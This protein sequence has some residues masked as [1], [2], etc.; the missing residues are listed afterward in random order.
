[1]YKF[2]ESFLGEY[3]EILG[4]IRLENSATYRLKI[5]LKIYILLNDYQFYFFFSFKLFPL[6]IPCSSVWTKFLLITRRAKFFFLTND[7]EYFYI[8]IAGFPDFASCVSVSRSS[9]KSARATVPRPNH[10][11]VTLIPW[12]SHRFPAPFE[13]LS[14]VIRVF[15]VRWTR[16]Y[17][18]ASFRPFFSPTENF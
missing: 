4:M 13:L 16:S 18:P 7:R 10:S 1:M 5:I 17:R 3:D 8:W 11:I 9:N 15:H 6:V 14:L 2:P 12:R